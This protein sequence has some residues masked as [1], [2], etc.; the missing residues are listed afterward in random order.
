MRCTDWMW[1]GTLIGLQA[2]AAPPDSAVTVIKTD[3]GV[4]L[5]QGKERFDIRGVGGANRFEELA[6]I[7][8]N[9]VRTWGAGQLDETRIGADGVERPFLDHAHRLG[10]RVCA[11]FWLEHP[12]HGYDYSDAA[13]VEKQLTDLESF[14]RRHKDH[15]A[16]M[17]WGIGNEVE[18]GADVE[19]VFPHL[20]EAAR[21]VRA[22]DPHHPT[23]IVI[24]EIGDDKARLFKELCPDVDLLGINSYGGIASLPERLAAQGYEG[25]YLVTEFGL[26]GHWETG[27]TPWGA[28]YEPT[29][30][31]KADFLRN[32]MTTT[33]SGD[34]NCLGGFAFLW[35][36]KQ[37]RT[38]T[39]YGMWLP[40]GEALA[41]VDA[42]C[43]TWTGKHRTNRAPLVSIPS[44][45]QPV[46]NVAPGQPL[47]ATVELSDP[48]G[49]ALEVTWIIREESTDHRMGGDA[50]AAA[51]E[52]ESLTRTTTDGKVTV[53][54]PANPGAYRLF[55]Y[56]RDGHGNAGTSNV[57]FRIPD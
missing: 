3:E 19:T 7:G 26:P 21:R 24:A 13:F 37:E 1:L 9:A 28:P 15:P 44:L 10:I 33:I 38:A 55:V 49:D 14:V 39:W 29:S 32:C 51:R 57:A 16:V 50:E 53:T 45:S 34:P 8:G 25:P 12:R 54:A 36:W 27:A 48:D 2:C 30:A 42:L 20:N 41:S 4:M 52:L 23:M 40:G 56:A 5:Q 43:E 17:I 11:G 47:G 35:G 31:D 46:D 22:I 18:L 6:A